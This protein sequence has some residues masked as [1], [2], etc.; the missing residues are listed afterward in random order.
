MSMSTQVYIGPYL[1][2]KTIEQT[3]EEKTRVCSKNK[4]HKQDQWSNS[5]KHCS[6]CGGKI[7]VAMVSEEVPLS[8]GYVVFEKDEDEYTK[9]EKKL[10]RWFD[11]VESSNVGFNK[12]GYEILLCPTTR[13]FSGDEEK[14]HNVKPEQFSAMGKEVN[15]NALK[16]LQKTMKY[17]SIEAK[18]GVI[19][20]IA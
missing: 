16:L 9:D 6:E 10:M 7:I 11:P 5:K 19:I 12:D 18:H 17:K 4:K 20:S 13:G 3:I 1:V 14:I 8:L 2:C 15:P